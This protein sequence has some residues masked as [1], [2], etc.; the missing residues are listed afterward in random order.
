[1][2][3]PVGEHKSLECRT[4]E[5]RYLRY[6]ELCHKKDLRYFDTSCG[7]WRGVWMGGVAELHIPLIF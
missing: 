1:M 3:D 4:A 6:F 7:W 5:C 2:I